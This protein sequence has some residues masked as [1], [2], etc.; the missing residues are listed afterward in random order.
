MLESNLEDIQLKKKLDDHLE[1]VRTSAKHKLKVVQQK[2]KAAK[3]FK[4]FGKK[5]FKEQKN[6]FEKISKNE[7]LEI[8]T[9]P[10]NVYSK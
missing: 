8:L 1:E 10:D 4:S 9:N 6:D 5:N 3:L 2:L 7:A